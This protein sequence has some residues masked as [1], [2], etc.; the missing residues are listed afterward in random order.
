MTR[1]APRVNSFE[2]DLA[3]NAV[4]THLRMVEECDAMPLDAE[5]SEIHCQV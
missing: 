1:L 4:D 2:V 3:R 5:F